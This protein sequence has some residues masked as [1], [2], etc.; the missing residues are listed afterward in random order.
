[1]NKEKLLFNMSFLTLKPT[2]VVLLLS[3]IGLNKAFGKFPINN[4]AVKA[5]SYRTYNIGK[6]LPSEKNHIYAKQ[7]KDNFSP[8]GAANNLFVTLYKNI[9]GTADYAQ[10]DQIKLLVN[11]SLASNGVGTNKL[12]NPSDNLA[13]IEGTKV[14]AIDGYKTIATKDTITISVDLLT[15]SLAYKLKV[16]ATAF[17]V[18]GFVPMLLDRFTN[19][20]TTLVADTALISFTPTA[21]TNTFGK[22]F[23]IVFKATGLPVKQINL[24]A[25][26]ESNNVIVNWNTVDEVGVINYTVQSSDNTTSFTDLSTIR[27][28]NDANAS[29]TFVDANSNS[30]FYRIKATDITGVVSYSKIMAVSGAT[31]ARII[32]FPNPLVGN[33][34]H[35]STNSLSTGKYNVVLHNTI[36]QRVFSGEIDGSVINHNLKIG[37]LTAGQYVLTMSK[38]GKVVYNTSLQVR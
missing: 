38:E 4:D 9:T 1:M 19:T 31:G 13:F 25:I 5:L 24:S 15:T 27:A 18:S 17:A 3:F 32:A 28:K 36:G 21:A 16:D 34:L 35:L 2:V 20:L 12:P 29:Y 8:L 30:S 33:V 22:R 37:S 11:S 6:S 14:L 26:K 7:M 23:A 10:A